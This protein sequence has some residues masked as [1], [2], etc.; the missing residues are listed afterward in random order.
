MKK[1]EYA[2]VWWLP[3]V[4]E[5]K[6]SGTLNIIYGEG[7]ILTL[8]ESFSKNNNDNELKVL[9]PKI[10][11][12]KSTDDKEITLYN[13][14]EIVP[15]LDSIGMPSRLY[16]DTAFIGVHFP[17]EED[18]K[19]TDLTFKCTYLDDW[20]NIAS[21]ELE[22]VSKD[23]IILKFKNPKPIKVNIDDFTITFKSK[24]QFEDLFEAKEDKF[25]NVEEMKIMPKK[26]ISI[27]ALNERHLTE[28]LRIIFHLLRFIS[29]GLNF[30]VY[31]QEIKG[32]SEAKKE[33]IGKKTYRYEV[34]EIFHNV[35]KFNQQITELSEVDFLFTCRDIKDKLEEVL[36]IWF[37]HSA[38]FEKVYDT[39]FEILYNRQ[40]SLEHKFL[41]LVRAL[42]IYYDFNSKMH[43]LGKSYALSEDRWNSVKNEI[44][45][46][47]FNML[48]EKEAN[49]LMRNLD[50]LNRFPLEEKL[51]YILN[52]CL[53]QYLK[54]LNEFID[55]FIT[56]END[57]I[58]K[59]V[60]IKDRL[61]N[62]TNEYIS[63]GKSIKSSELRNIVLNLKRLLE[64]CILRD[65]NFS[66]ETI[67][68]IYSKRSIKDLKRQLEEMEA[69]L[70][71]DPNVFRKS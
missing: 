3:E 4:P 55:D 24:F 64:I 28:F 67:K 70:M 17:K 10:I 69:E 23:E 53:G 29:L 22:D 16:C 45:N 41:S 27:I 54:E 1:I 12:G 47:I 42:E 32:I 8:S 48:S 13:C 31:L 49:I 50:C 35:S 43:N 61:S 57:F 33:K 37:K 25:L 26:S 51:G 5:N 18:I 46:L 21:I 65:L 30:P 6:V 52:N 66:F 7:I 14:Y 39:Y 63:K 56:D 68:K 20:L 38:L 44:I 59:I 58:E 15:Y 9:N 71:N 40:I 62:S 2:G 36:Q 11:L 19:F 34:I 60:M